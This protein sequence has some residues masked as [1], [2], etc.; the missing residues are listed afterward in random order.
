[1]WKTDQ[2]FSESI[3]HNQ[4]LGV[5]F[6]RITSGIHHDDRNSK[7]MND[8]LE[9]FMVNG[10][11]NRARFAIVQKIDLALC[12]HAVEQSTRESALQ[13]INTD[14]HYVS[15][16]LEYFDQN[17]E[18]EELRQSVDHVVDSNIL[19]L[20]AYYATDHPLINIHIIPTI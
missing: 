10:L 15:S 20:K 19:E 3:N 8:L 13:H 4:S 16:L 11:K 9:L 17:Q 7:E 1:M 5:M 12:Y 6:S 18:I 2:L 14:L